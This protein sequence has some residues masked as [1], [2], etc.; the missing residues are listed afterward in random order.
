MTKRFFSKLCFTG[1][2]I[3]TIVL[4]VI[5]SIKSYQSAL[6]ANYIITMW[7]ILFI[8]GI[9]IILSVLLQE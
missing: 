6:P 1:A 5:M 7:P 9:L 3:I 4:I 8:A 2:A